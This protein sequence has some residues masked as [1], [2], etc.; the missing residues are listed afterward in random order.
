MVVGSIPTGR[1]LM[2]RAEF[3]MGPILILHDIRSV[4]NVGALFR[5]ADAVGVSKIYCTGVTPTPIDRFGRVR[6]DFVK[7]SL[8]AEKTVAWEACELGELLKR[9]KKEGVEL[10][11]VEQS[12]DALDYKNF[13]PKGECA[14]ILGSET[15]G[16][17]QEILKKMD[18]VIEI[19]MRGTKES[20]N[21]SVAGGIVLYRLFDR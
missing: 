9:L 16:V 8:G 2:R 3:S 1:I 20:L 18:A 12:A 5:T 19:P 17:P 4:H 14:L 10:V 11:A 7:T 21:V 13:A 15:E 6:K